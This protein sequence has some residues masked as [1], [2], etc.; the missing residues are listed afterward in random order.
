MFRAGMI[1]ACPP[2]SGARRRGYPP[3]AIRSFCDRVGVA[4]RENVI[5]LSS[6]EFDVRQHLNKTAPRVMVVLNPL[7]LI[8]SNYPE[9][10]TEWL[11]VEN[12]PEDPRSGIR[13]LPFGRELYI[14]REDFMEDPPK[15]FFRLGP[16]RHVR[17]KG[18]YIIR[19]DEVIKDDAGQVTALHCSYFPDSQ[20][21]RRYQWH[22]GQRGFAFCLRS[23]CPRGGGASIRPPFF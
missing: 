14:E 23:T 15:K 2:L 9:D 18:A 19:C 4:K 5:D 7:K 11:E 1:R 10:K 20:E 8:I 6:L 17:L 13:K 22:Q 21:R 12:N 3:E 16:G